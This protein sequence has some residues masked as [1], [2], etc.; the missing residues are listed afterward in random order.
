[1]CFLYFLSL[2][3]GYAL[4]P[5]TLTTIHAVQQKQSCEL[6]LRRL[7][8]YQSA[9]PLLIPH[10]PSLTYNTL[11]F[12]PPK[13]LS[14]LHTFHRFCCRENNS[15]L[16]IWIPGLK[17]TKVNFVFFKAR[18]FSFLHLKSFG[19]LANSC[20][21][22]QRLLSTQSAIVHSLGGVVVVATAG[23]ILHMTAHPFLIKRYYLICMID[24]F[25]Q[26]GDYTFHGFIA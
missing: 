19:K 20:V 13:K 15:K 7:N 2:I 8:E 11:C 18:F 17:I 14:P 12:P 4:P 26:N 3:R 5:P 22:E 6:P 1:M 23:R 16:L 21:E 24:L 10:G 25:H 9:S